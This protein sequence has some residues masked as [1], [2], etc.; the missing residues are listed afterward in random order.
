MPS[1]SGT[2]SARTL[3]SSVCTSAS[4]AVGGIAIL[5][6][7]TSCSTHPRINPNQQMPLVK[8]QPYKSSHR[9]MDYHIAFA[10]TFHGGG[11][12]GADR[13]EFSGHLVPRRGLDTFVLR[14]HFLDESG[15]VLGT[16]ILYAPG[17]GRGA[18]R[19]TINRMMEVPTGAVNIGFS[20]VA[21]EKRILR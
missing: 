12:G 9:T 11:G 4:V 16:Q 1:F 21:R 10:Y 18:G 13:I 6:M 17:A 15:H 8:L 14:F 19:A 5:L 7:L 3:M 20:D 2:I